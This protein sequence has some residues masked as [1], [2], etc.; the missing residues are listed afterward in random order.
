VPHDVLLDEVL[1]RAL[2][3]TVH[4]RRGEGPQLGGQLLHGLGDL[5][6]RP[7]VADQRLVDV[8]MEELDLGVGDLGHRL[9][10]HARDLEEGDERE[11]GI[12]DGGHVAEQLDVLVAQ[13]VERGGGLAGGG[14]DP[15]DQRG[16]E[17]DL[18]GDLFQRAGRLVGGE[19]VLDVAVR[20]PSRPRRALDLGERVAAGAQPGDEPGVRDRRRRPLAV[21]ER[22][23]A[24]ADPAPERV[25]GDVD[26]PR[27]LGERQLV[28]GEK[29]RRNR[30]S[31]SA[32]CGQ[33]GPL[34]RPA[35][36]VEGD[37]LQGISQIPTPRPVAW[38]GS[39]K[40]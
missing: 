15:F 22:H 13:L 23:H 34:P 2:V 31:D 21:V 39:D 40:V 29:K 8:E 32:A 6:S 28:H 33:C 36:F 37:A 12:E 14:P 16:L 9:P 19:H 25:G 30:S 18:V 24:L 17:P 7:A 5:E 10:V 26:P 1:Q 27:H 20:E 38:F 4:D 35:A 11:A 3:E